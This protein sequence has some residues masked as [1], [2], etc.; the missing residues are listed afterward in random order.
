MAEEDRLVTIAAFSLPHEAHLA[1]LRL[2][3]EGIPCFV[4]DENIV[5]INW[6]YSN[7][8][9]GESHVLS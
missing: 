9:R 1:R 5:A 8:A 6:L 7:A 2:E 4:V 3:A